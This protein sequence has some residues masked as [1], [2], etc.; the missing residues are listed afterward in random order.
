[1]ADTIETVYKNGARFDGWSESF[2]WDGWLAAFEANGVD[3]EQSIKAMPFSTDL[4]WSHIAKGPSTDHLERERQRTSMKLKEYTPINLADL[5]TTTDQPAQEFGRGRKKIASRNP[6]APTKN[7]VRIRWGKTERSRFL[8]HLDNIRMI[9]MAMR[10]ADLPVEYS[11]GFNPSP[12][13]S[14]GPPLSLGMTSEAEYVDL[15]LTSSFTGSMLE[16]FKNAMSAGYYI[17]EANTILGSPRS[18]SSRLNRA[19][20]ELAASEFKTTDTLNELIE[21]LLSQPALF[22]ERINKKGAKQVDI[23]PGLFDLRF[24]NDKLSMELGIGE[25]IFVRPSEVVSYMTDHLSCEIPALAFHRSG[26]YHLEENGRRI[27]ALEL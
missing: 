27:D 16:R 5:E 19:G 18:L 14:F 21:N 22:V 10:R 23:R 11:Q 3:P 24:E 7:R 26:M 15:L 25:G 12:R 20:Y 8:S 13:I 6:L 9:E 2:D 17:V 1:M 4:P